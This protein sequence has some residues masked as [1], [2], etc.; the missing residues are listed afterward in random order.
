MR[1]ALMDG[2][3]GILQKWCHLEFEKIQ[4]SRARQAWAK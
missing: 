1:P 2:S 4:R 3:T